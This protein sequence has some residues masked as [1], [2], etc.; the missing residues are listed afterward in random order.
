MDMMYLHLPPATRKT[1]LSSL[2]S[3]TWFRGYFHISPPEKS[4]PTNSTTFCLSFS[5]QTAL[6]LIPLL[7][8]HRREKK[9]GNAYDSMP[10]VIVRGWPLL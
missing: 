7:L 1:H 6:L 4:L 2:E 9:A 3:I 5:A 8:L 10:T